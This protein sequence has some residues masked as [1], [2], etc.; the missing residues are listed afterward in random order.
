VQTSAG[1]Q[2]D[3]LRQRLKYICKHIAANLTL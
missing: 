1:R 3:Q 2:Y